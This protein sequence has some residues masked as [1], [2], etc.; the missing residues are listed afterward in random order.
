M[1][2]IKEQNRK[3]YREL[4]DEAFNIMQDLIQN[5][6]QSF[7][8]LFLI[9]DKNTLTTERPDVEYME[10]T[11]EHAIE[12]KGVLDVA[13]EVNMEVSNKKLNDLVDQMD[14]LEDKL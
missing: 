13:L 2:I 3:T 7:P 8:E 4:G 9:K 10:V 6:P 14:E 1:T 12:L 11:F 5:E